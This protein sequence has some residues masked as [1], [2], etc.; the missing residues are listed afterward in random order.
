MDKIITRYM[1]LFLKPID[2]LK[3]EIPLN[4]KFYRDQLK[5]KIDN[6]GFPAEQIL[7][8]IQETSDTY[9]TGSFLL[10]YLTEPTDWDAGDIDVFTTDTTLHKKLESHMKGFTKA[11]FGL[12]EVVRN[13]EEEYPSGPGNYIKDLYEWESN[14]DKTRKFQIIL[15]DPDIT[16]DEVIDK[17]DFA[18]VKSRFD[19]FKITIPDKTMSSLLTRQTRIDSVF[20]CDYKLERTLVRKKKYEERGYSVMLPIYVTLENIPNHIYT[21]MKPKISVP[22]TYSASTK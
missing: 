15:I 14:D 9:I 12:D 1:R 19:G 7:K 10:H 21:Y 20:F 2:N 17:F 4:D 11:R 13:G 16:A 3:F 18:M 5:T 22:R 8:I 6:F